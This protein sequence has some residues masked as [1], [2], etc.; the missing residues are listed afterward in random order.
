MDTKLKLYLISIP[1]VILLLAVTVFCFYIVFFNG[2][3]IRVR[4]V[5]MSGTELSPVALTNGET[6]VPRFAFRERLA[7]NRT[8]SL[9]MPVNGDGRC[10]LTY[11]IDGK[12]YEL[13][14]DDHAKYQ[15]QDY[16]ITVATPPEITVTRKSGKLFRTVDGTTAEQ[17]PELDSPPAWVEAARN[18]TVFRLL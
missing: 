15:T 14:L 1:A 11:A 5:N 16:I 4:L 10:R 12:Y 2:T 18:H 3:R 9:R 7:Q 8:W 6:P 13:E 17:M